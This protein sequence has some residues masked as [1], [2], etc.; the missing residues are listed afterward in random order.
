M[1]TKKIWGN[2]EKIFNLNNV[3]IHRIEINKHTYCSEHI[4]EYKHNLFY[5]ESGKIVV[6]YWENNNEKK[7]IVLEKGKF[8]SIAPKIM[9]QFIGLEDSVVF[10]I[11]WVELL[12]D[13][14]KRR[15]IGGKL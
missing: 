14:I 6:N 1:K 9:H 4:H 5:V 10:E 8:Y 2:T 15:T 13:D 11:Y 7:S 3:E 12:D